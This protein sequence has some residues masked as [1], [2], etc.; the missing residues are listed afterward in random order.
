MSA[1]FGKHPSLREYL[2]WARSEEGCDLKEAVHGTSS[3]FRLEAPNGRSLII[4]GVPDSERLTPSMVAH[5]DRRLGV[6][7]GYPSAPDE[8]E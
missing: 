1:P 2:E 4:A 5:Y 3:V 8:Y 6:V 7:S